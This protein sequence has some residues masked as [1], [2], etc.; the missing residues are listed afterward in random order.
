MTGDSVSRV[1][2]LGVGYCVPD[3]I[4]DNDDP[5]FAYLNSHKPDKNA[6]IF[7]GLKHRRVLAKPEDVVDIMVQAAIRAL[8]DAGK[9]PGDVDMLFGSASVSQYNAPNDLAAVHAKLKLSNQCRVLTLNT[10]YT[11]F[12]DGM[13]LANDLVSVGTAKCALVVCG[14]NWTHH[15]DYQ[16]SVALAA[17]DGAGAA[18]VGWTIDA[19]KFRLVDWDNETRTDLFGALR[20]APRVAS[21]ATPAVPSTQPAEVFSPPLMKLDDQRGGSA[22]K[23]FGF[24]EAGVVV[25]RLLQRNNVLAQDVTLI[26]HQTSKPVCDRWANDIRPGQFIGSLEDFGDMVMASVPVFWGKFQAD[27]QMDHLVLLGIGM[28]MRVTALLYHRG[29]EATTAT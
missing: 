18:V 5:V 4:R 29:P 23:G 28:E 3:A 24:P 13:K 10:E 22:V 26:A 19:S 27:I 9:L 12:H 2:T 1:A 8:S 14:C 20:M 17:S 11:N 16:E 25:H 7:A 21:P 15:V 6:D